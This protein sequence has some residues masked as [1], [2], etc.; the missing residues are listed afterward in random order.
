M[1]R[2]TLLT[3]SLGATLAIILGTQAGA[4]D[5][6]DQTQASFDTV[7]AFMGAMGSGDME[8]M[9]KLMADDMVW[10]NEGDDSLPWIGGAT[11]KENIFKFLGVFSENVQTIKWENTDA[12]AS[13]DTVAVFGVMNAITPHSGKETG[14]FT[15]ALRAKVRDGQV[16]LWHWF[17]DSFAVSQAYHGK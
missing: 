6:D 14:D 12:F 13:G 15:F 11:G 9:G 4:Q 8:T 3:T 2:R 1:N 5:M 16:V 7:M 17:E 10:H